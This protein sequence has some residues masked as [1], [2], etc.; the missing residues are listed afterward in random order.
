MTVGEGGGGLQPMR[1]C[2]VLT[3]LRDLCLSALL[4]IWVARVTRTMATLCNNV[5]FRY[6]TL[7]A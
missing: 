4:V 5:L 3:E 1:M 2:V 7:A 6:V